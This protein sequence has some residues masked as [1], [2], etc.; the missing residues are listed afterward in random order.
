ML[1]VILAGHTLDREFVLAL[2]RGDLPADVDPTPE[3]ISAAYARISR[4]PEPIP[5]LRAQA[6]RDVPASRKSNRTIVFRMGHHSVAEHVQLNFD[7]LGVSRLALEAL[8]DARLCSYTEKSQRYV[9]F[10]GEHVVP[11][12]FGP[13]ERELFETTAGEQIAFYR[14]AF[15][16]LLELQRRRNPD[17]L[18]TKTG[19]ETVE[20]WAKEDARYALGL[21]TETQ[22]GFSGNARNIEHV[23]RKLRHHPLAEVRAL[24]RGLFEAAS[25]VA[26]SLII[27]SDP[28][29]FREAFGRDVSDAFVA[30]GRA[31]IERLA[32]EAMASARPAAASVGWT[33]GDVT[34]LGGP[35]DPDAAVLAALLHSGS[36]LP[37]ADCSARA[38]VM[39]PGERRGFVRD[40]LA[41][42]SEFDALPREFEAASFTFEIVLSAACF[43]QLKRHRMMTLAAQPYDPGLG[44]TVPDAVREAGLED[45]LRTLAHRTADAFG[46]LAAVAPRAAEYVL[47]NA[48]RR[49]ALAVIDLREIHHMARLRMDKHAQWDIR[50][51]TAAITALACR[52]APATSALACGKDAFAEAR[53]ALRA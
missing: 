22:L 8:E 27:L 45:G 24:S 9:T 29:R 2:R 11:E 41:E 12:E 31:T 17:M 37:Y 52:A 50:N 19:A 25:E 30:R 13:A 53:S 44:I 36:G 15:E 10:G 49:R 5:E 42:L 21:A 34:L 51:V 23:V 26:P 1:K 38:K 35:A 20:G 6:R 39:S 18:G 3:T 14:R 47:C 32:R 40:A 4:F 28:E 7:I 16:K 43:G 33:E 48:H 46:R